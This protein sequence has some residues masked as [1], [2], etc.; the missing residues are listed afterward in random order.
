VGADALLTF[1]N[2][3]LIAA[4]TRAEAAGARNDEI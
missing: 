1:L 3:G 2:E 4:R